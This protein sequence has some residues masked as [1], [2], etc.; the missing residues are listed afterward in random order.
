MNQQLYNYCLKLLSKR[1]YSEYKIREKIIT[2]GLDKEECQIIIKKLKEE[3][4]L[5]ANRYINEKVQHLANKGYSLQYIQ[6]KLH[7]EEISIST[8]EIQNVIDEAAINT[9]SVIKTLLDRKISQYV[10]KKSNLTEQQLISKSLLFLSSKGY[11]Y[12][13]AVDLLPRELSDNIN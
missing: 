13:Q 4:F 2:R 3:K 6:E 7:L 8:N 11:D 12:H 5:N 9:A 10:S 1:D